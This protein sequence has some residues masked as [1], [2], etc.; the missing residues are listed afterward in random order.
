MLAPDLMC[1]E[2]AVVTWTVSTPFEMSRPWVFVMKCSRV[3]LLS[4]LCLSL[5]VGCPPTDPSLDNNDPG[6]SNSNS[7][8][9]TSNNQGSNNSTSPGE[10]MGPVDMAEQLP[11]GEDITVA[12]LNVQRL[13]DS[14]C[15][16]GQC[17][18]GD[19]EEVI[20]ELSLK[21]KI[22]RIQAGIMAIDADVVVLQEIETEALFDQI[23]EPLSDTY[24]SQVFGETGFS[25]SLDVAIL[26]KG[27]FISSDTH[28]DERITLDD[29]S[30]DRFAREFLELQVDVRGERVV[31]FGAH[32]I[33]KRSDSDGDR[34]L[35]EARAAASIAAGVAEERPDAL[36]VIA[37]DLNDTP[38]SKTLTAIEAG[39]FVVTADG[40]DPGEYYTHVFSGQ[41][42]IL[43]HVVFYDR[44]RI[45]VPR[46][47]LEVMRDEGRQGFAGSD[48]ASPRLR[49]R[50]V[51]E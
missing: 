40:L 7:N 43:D 47:G 3:L 34:R 38:A 5:L 25:A 12:T 30:T 18:A 4:C 10:D 9:G 49:V 41:E 19:F 50:L 36:V 20:S 29:G 1:K 17:D 26:S 33:S 45:I 8:N 28:R 48:H 42:Q 15:N 13:F 14:Q 32:F 35:A 31:V 11:A 37:G 2:R 24:P 22:E 16:S 39:G 44:D 51:A 21:T 6:D 46:D 23:M 27:N